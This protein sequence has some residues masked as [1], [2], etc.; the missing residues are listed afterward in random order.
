MSLL[1]HEDKRAE[2]ALKMGLTQLSHATGS[3]LSIARDIPSLK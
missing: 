2:M 1:V 3:K